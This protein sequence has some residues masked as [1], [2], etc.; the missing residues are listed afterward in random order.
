[1][2]LAGYLP[3]LVWA[4]PVWLALVTTLV[5][6]LQGAALGRR[7]GAMKV[8]IV[9]M[10]VFAL[11]L[12]LGGGLVRDVML[13]SFPVSAL[14]SPW[15]TVMVIVAVVAMLVVG[16]WVPIDGRI[17]VALDALT[18]G[19]YA[20]IGTQK[21]ITFHVSIAGAVIVGLFASLSGGVI[22]SVLQGVRPS[23]LAP[24]APYGLLAL[25]GIVVYLALVRV[26]SEAAAL[27]CVAFVVVARFVTI[28]FGITS[29][30]VPKLPHPDDAAGR[31]GSA[32]PGATIP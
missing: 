17:F 24:S 19:L 6:A 7:P 1:M 9:G 32:D 21:A 30:A 5:G 15:Y 23:L 3:N 2:L 13:G 22:V 16:R 4:T 27:S 12:G 25:G 31:D 14:Q 29:P 28:H 18:L 11:F 20:A 10:F 8:D 26:N